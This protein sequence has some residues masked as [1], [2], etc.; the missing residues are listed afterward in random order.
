MKKI[1]RR[2]F[3]KTIAVGGAALGIGNIVTLNALNG[4]AAISTSEKPVVSVAK[5][6]NGNVDYAVR[7]ATIGCCP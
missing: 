5:I 7:Q 1:C 6:Q 4:S 2:D 3:M